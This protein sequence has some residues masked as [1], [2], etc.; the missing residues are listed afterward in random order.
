MKNFRTLD[1]LETDYLADHPERLYE[2]IRLIFDAYYEDEDLSALMASL[3]VIGRVHG[4]SR[5]AEQTHTTRKGIQK[6]LSD[7]GNP[8][9]AMVLSILSS[10]GYALVPVKK[11]T[12]PHHPMT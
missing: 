1:D 12:L 7:K 10:M 11:N 5:L 4:I 3:R 9:F 8:S 2:Y 6:A